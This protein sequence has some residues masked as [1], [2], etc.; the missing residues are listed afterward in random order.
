MAVKPYRRGKKYGGV[1]T[2]YH[3]KRGEA[4]SWR[5]GFGASSFLIA[6][7]SGFSIAEG[8]KMFRRLED[9]WARRIKARRPVRS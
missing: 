6:S 3:F 7:G 5:I 9:E 4:G 2:P 1:T 8:M